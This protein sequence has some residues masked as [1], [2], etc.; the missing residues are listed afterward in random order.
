MTSLRI[1]RFFIQ[2]PVWQSLLSIVFLLLVGVVLIFLRI[3]PSDKML[4]LHYT[5]PFGIDLVGPWYRLYEIPFA[6]F[7]FALLNF[8]LAYIFY[9]KQR[10]VAIIIVIAT[11]LLE[12]TLLVGLYLIVTQ[13]AT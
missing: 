3:Q 13:N 8:I 9:T 12:V 11:V 10:N 6:G 2:T 5:I 7:V 4:I 1:K